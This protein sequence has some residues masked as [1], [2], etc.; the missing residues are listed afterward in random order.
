MSHLQEIVSY[1][2]LD[3][4][5]RAVLMREQKAIVYVML[6]KDEHLCSYGTSLETGWTHKTAYIYF[7]D[8]TSTALCHC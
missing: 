7:P 2:P 8:I 4:A 3:D 5:H 6:V 1:I